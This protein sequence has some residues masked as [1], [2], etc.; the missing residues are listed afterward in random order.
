MADQFSQTLSHEETF[1]QYRP[2][3]FT[4]A[5]RMLGSVM[6]AEDAIQETYL[7]YMATVRL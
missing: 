3:L 6:E 7:R 5:Y 1:S 4:I 2:Y